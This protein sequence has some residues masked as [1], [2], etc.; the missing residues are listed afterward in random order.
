MRTPLSRKV[1][2]NRAGTTEAS[3]LCD[4]T[5]KFAAIQKLSR[6][7]PHTC[8]PVPAGLGQVRKTLSPCALPFLRV[9][10]LRTTFA[11]SLF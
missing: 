8:R 11:M 5:L 4:L 10:C 9:V 1:R 6:R 7:R 3:T 2:V